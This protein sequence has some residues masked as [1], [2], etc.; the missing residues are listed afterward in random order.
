MSR[1]QEAMLAGKDSALTD[2]R[3]ANGSATS[4]DVLCDITFNLDKGLRVGICGRSGSGKSSLLAA[5]LR[6][7][8]DGLVGGDIAMMGRD[9]A[10]MSLRDWR[11][12]FSYV[13]QDPLVWEASVREVLLVR[14]FAEDVKTSPEDDALW[15]VLDTV[16]L[17]A[18]IR[19]T[20]HGLGTKLLPPGSS[21]PDG[22]KH[23]VLSVSQTHLVAFARTL[24][25]KGRHFLL[26][27]ELTSNLDQKAEELTIDLILRSPVLKDRTILAVSHRIGECARRSSAQPPYFH[28]DPCSVF[29][30][31]RTGF[32]VSFDY[33]FLMEG[34]EIVERGSP[35]EL[36]ATQSRFKRLC[37]LQGVRRR[38]PT[39]AGPG[40]I[41]VE[42]GG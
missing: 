21:P 41:E 20:A 27:D 7:V 31:T 29:V 5:L 12:C 32:I 9:R 11:R 14:D 3:L 10:T 2:S 18:D 36:L 15:E 1:F 38:A 35:Q 4:P 37:D 25:E 16:G 33:I 23:L 13:T 22:D 28:A 24:L 30:P 34:G 19:E 26:M 40:P 39:S 8:S 6:G 42:V 17:G